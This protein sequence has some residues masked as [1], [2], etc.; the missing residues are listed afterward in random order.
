M[1]RDIKTREGFEFWDKLN[2][3][4]RYAFLLSP[5]GNSV[6][7][8]EDKAL[9]NWIDVHEAQKVVD[10]AQDRI[11]EL[12]EDL[13]RQKRYV[14]INGN[15]A[16]G[17]HMEGQRY[18]DERDALQLR[19]NA[20]DQALDEADDGFSLLSLEAGRRMD[21]LEGLLRGWLDLFPKQGVTGGPITTQKER[22]VA[23][24]KPLS[25]E[26]DHQIPGTSGMRLNMLANQGE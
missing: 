8:F 16:H 5:S 4:P 23:A 26:P 3:L 7:K 12:Q 20:A 13:E 17:K 15:S 14:E 24:L 2:T 18:R 11:G 22:T 10:Q 21:L 25:I 6:Q 1:M 19:L 9:G